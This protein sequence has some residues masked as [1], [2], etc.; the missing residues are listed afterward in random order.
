MKR[1]VLQWV[2]ALT[3]VLAVT[4]HATNFQEVKVG[5]SGLKVGTFGNAWT[6]FQVN[7]VT[8]AVSQT[9]TVVT[10]HGFVYTNLTQTTGDALR[11]VLDDDF[12]TTGKYLNFLG[13]TGHDT[14]VF[15]VGEGGAT[16]VTDG[17]IW[18]S[19]TLIVTDGVSPSYKGI[20]SNITV[21]AAVTG[22]TQYI[23]ALQGMVTSAASSAPAETWG[24]YGINN[25]NGGAIAAYGAVG[26]LTV[27]GTGTIG[28][29]A[30]NTFLSAGYFHSDVAATKTISGIQAVPLVGIIETST[31]RRKAEAAVGAVLAGAINQS[32]AGAGAAYKVYDFNTGA[33]FDYGLDLYYSS[34][35]YTNSFV[36]ADIRLVNQETISNAADGIVSISGAVG[37]NVAGGTAVASTGVLGGAG[38]STSAPQTIGSGSATAFNFFTQST[39]T[40]AT[41]SVSGIRYTMMY[42]T[43]G[44]S[45]A[46]AGDA[47]RGRAWLVGDAAG[48]VAVTGGSFSTEL[49]ATT[50]S[51]TG[52]AVGC[53]GNIVLPSG[54]MTNSGTYYGT[55]AEVFLGGAATDTLAYTRIA[56]LGI[57]VGGTAPTA[58]SQV[59]NMDAIAI[60]VPA[61][62]VTSDATMVVTGGA[63]DTCDAKLKIS[64]NGTN[65][66]I[67]L[68]VDD[69]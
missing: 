39:S 52:L 54:V 65:Y 17:T 57:V 22:S 25:V 59:A 45:A 55:M 20:Y 3:V 9:P 5:T 63:A 8:G 35:S 41:H 51:S 58:A 2:I 11:V 48:A 68:S 6:R 49:A 29:G 61:N 14:T 44:S 24:V 16:T 40:T 4:A 46:P 50:A 38:T 13:G 28:T 12:L 1:F 53:R 60:D 19:D 47:I 34:G 32:T 33:S 36:G 56:P 42:G 69:E 67:M 66:W 7:G 27:A 10:G 43:S 62:M 23:K 30:V 37:F 15:S 18:Q 21:P 64:I 31:G 26:E